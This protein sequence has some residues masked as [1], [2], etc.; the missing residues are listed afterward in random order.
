MALLDFFR[1]VGKL[2]IGSEA[3]YN[4]EVI[5]NIIAGNTFNIEDAHN[6]STTYTCIKVLSGTVSRLPLNVYQQKEGEGRL[7]DKKDYRYDLLHYNPNS[8]TT[9]QSFF[10]A[11][12]TY[13]NLKGNAFARIYRNKG[14]GKIESLEIIPPS[15]VIEYAI[16]NGQ[17]YY[18]VSKKVDGK[19]KIETLNANDLLHFKSSVTKDGIWGLNPIEAIRLNLSTTFKGYKTIDSFYDNNATSPK[20][21]KSTVSGANQKAMLEAVEDFKKK[22]SGYTKAG[23]IMALPPNTELQDL[24]LNF[25]DA[26]F[27]STIKYNASQIASIFGIPP[28][29]VG[30]FEASKWNNVE[31]MQLD[32]K[33]NTIAEILKI[34]R[35]ELEFKLLSLKERKAGKSIEFNDKGLIETDYKT[36]IES[37]KAMHQIGVLTSNQIA[38]LE[39]I[40]TY[41]EGDLHWIASNIQPI[42]GRNQNKAE[43]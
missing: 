25:E 35:Q 27:I 13:R 39:G 36:R 33:V 34:Y 17:L 30:L 41:S 4:S 29:I 12:E 18:K 11:L 8:Y 42:E 38:A 31:Q 16:V 2:W 26:E 5:P 23:Q 20:A 9:S 1:N 19:E 43:Q 24:L 6:I 21:I 14:S 32:F 15:R 22:Y 40:P 37:Y 7:V 28:H 10:A 3:A